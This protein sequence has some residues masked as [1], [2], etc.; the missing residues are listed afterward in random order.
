MLEVVLKR[1]LTVVAAT[2]LAASL[3]PELAGASGSRAKLELRKT[4]VGTILVNGRG[5]TLYAF[6]RDS[7]NKDSC[8]G[9][10]GC[11]T[12]WPALTTNGKPLEGSGVR[13]SLIGTISLKGGVKQVT[14]AGHPLYTYLGDSHPAQTS[15]V[16]VFQSGGYWPAVNAAGKEVK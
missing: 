11:L 1:T 6:T 16:N 4:K 9:I 14:Y 10:S 3:I 2:V 12:V 13:A 5:Y 15:Y 8:E 7:R